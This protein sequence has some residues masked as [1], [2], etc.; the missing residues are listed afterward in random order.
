[1]LEPLENRISPA[2]LVGNVLTY[3]DIDGD[4]VKVTFTNASMTPQDFGFS[5]GLVDG[6]TNSPQGLSFVALTGRTGGGFTLTATPHLG[7]GDS[8][9]N[10]LIID[11]SDTDLG[12]IAVDGDVSQMA[13]GSGAD[14][15]VGLKSFKALSMNRVSTINAI[16]EVKNAA[17]FTVTGDVTDIV[18]KFSGGI[19]TLA[20][21]GNLEETADLTRAGIHVTGDAGTIKIGGSIIARSGGDRNLF[22]DGDAGA[23]VIGGA[24]RGGSANLM[25]VGHGQ[26]EITGATKS[27][28]IGRDLAGGSG[29]GGGTLLASDGLDVLKIG[30]S[31][32]GGSGDYSGRVEIGNAGKTVFIGGSVVG[33]LAHL[34]SGMVEVFS[35]TSIRIAGSVIGNS[36]DVNSGVVSGGE[37]GSVVIGHDFIGGNST[38]AAALEASGLLS[39]RKLGSL[40]IGDFLGGRVLGN[41]SLD[42]KSSLIAIEETVGSV[43]INGSIL[44]DRSHL[45][46]LTVG[47]G[48]SVDAITA[49]QS[50]AVK[51]SVQS[52]S[53]LTGYDPTF[54]SLNP[55]AGIG[56]VTIGGNLAGS[57]ITVG[58]DKGSDGIAGNADDANI[59]NLATI[60]SVKVRGAFTGLAG[61]NT[62]FRIIGSEVLKLTIGKASYT[63]AQLLPGLTFS[64]IGN[65]SARSVF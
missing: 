17:S 39:F 40:T 5:T 30:G 51:G 41:G 45:A 34:H 48:S 15:S 7:K 63:Q 22:I 32:I 12:V 26:I 24:V 35:A 21:G 23:I 25:N 49:L 57:F 28:S 9:A 61:S 16:C 6:T 18:L 53:I 3:T 59:S 65:A 4:L 14:G 46:R 10:V 55:D 43:K 60:A 44:G 37:I 52:A 33:G 56:A 62:V 11:G 58:A 27:V 50:L 36:G 54:A 8:H 64:A 20:I 42:G 31:V 2:A 38:G 1:M 47:G 19:K 29:V 13:A